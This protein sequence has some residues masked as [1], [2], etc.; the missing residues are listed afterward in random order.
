MLYA[1]YPSNA[2]I[3][4]THVCKDTQTHTH[5]VFVVSLNA[6]VWFWNEFWDEPILIEKVIFIEM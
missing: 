1:D 3:S 4:H 2:V 6:K 5:S